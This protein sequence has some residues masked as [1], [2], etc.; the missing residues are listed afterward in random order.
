MLLLIFAFVFNYNNNVLAQKW[1][2]AGQIPN[3]GNEPSISVIDANNVW[4]AGGYPDTPK[5]YRT[6]NGGLNWIDVQTA[7][8]SKEL[9]CIW[10]VNVNTVY[11]GEGIVSGNAKLFKTTNAGL[12]WTV[13]LQTN[14]NQGYFN[15]LIFSY[16]NPLVGAA[17]AEKIYITTNGGVSWI[18][19]NP[20]GSGITSVQNSMMLID[21]NY[22]GFGMNSGT[23]RVNVTSDGGTTWV[24]QN[25]NLN[26]SIVSGFSYKDD[27]MTGLASTVNSIPNIARTTNGGN[28]WTTLNIGNNITGKTL[29]KWIPETNT[30]YIVGSNGTILK[31]TN[32]GLIWNTLSTTGVTGITHFSASKINN[33][34]HGYAI[35]NSGS[36]IKLTDSLLTMTGINKLG[37]ENPTEFKLFQ[38]YPNPFNPS[39]KIK[40][41]IPENKFV[42]L[43][44]FN[45]MGQEVSAPVNRKLTQG[46][47]EVEWNASEFPSGVYFYQL[48]IDNLKHSMMK[49]IL[50]K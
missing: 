9:F 27:K 42:T 49:M 38:N 17:M 26:G 32:D 5:V 45:L 24:A 25:I 31:S 35:S 10:A 46:T 40:F 6:T 22:F 23:S 2:L 30:V 18:Q 50:I 43:K 47:Y 36:V 34:V 7:G 14:P 15:N 12:N 44:I 13:V 21:G 28:T 8:I 3:P 29:I 1:V 41:Q 20:G 4:I 11:V 19:K 48:S 33:V 39:T 37:F 16:A